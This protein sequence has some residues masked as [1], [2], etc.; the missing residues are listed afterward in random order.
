MRTIE[1]K[2][3]VSSR[4]APQITLDRAVAIS[5]GEPITAQLPTEMTAGKQFLTATKYPRLA[6]APPEV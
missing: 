2:R 1:T 6:D 3:A 4:N 5:H